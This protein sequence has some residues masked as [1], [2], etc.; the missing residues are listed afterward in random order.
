MGIRLGKL[1][2]AKKNVRIVMLG[3]D[4]AGKTTLLY[5]LKLNEMVTT[6]P[7]IGF[8]VESV[9]YKNVNF[10][11]WDVGGQ[12]RIRKLWDYYFE[13]TFCL[14]FVIDS[15]DLMRMEEAK[16]EIWGIMNNP[17]MEGKPVLVF[18]NKQDVD[19][20]DSVEQ[21]T[22]KLG[23]LNCKSRKWNVQGCSALSGEGI[24]EGLDWLETQMK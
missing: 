15:S 19:Q 24:Y 9:S 14:I 18:A 3:L 23:L 20:V 21:I 4:N 17:E 6:I 10:T 11:I 7:T 2:K 22:I 16:E 1:F 8:N 13:N 12:D 5:K